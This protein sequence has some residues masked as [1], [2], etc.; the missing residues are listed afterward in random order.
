MFKHR[1]TGAQHNFDC[2]MK[3]KLS[4]QCDS[5]SQL[6]L[7][8]FHFPFSALEANVKSKLYF[9]PGG[10]CISLKGLPWWNKSILT[11]SAPC[12]NAWSSRWFSSGAGLFWKP[13]IIK[14]FS[15]HPSNY[16]RHWYTRLKRKWCLTVSQSFVIP[17][18]ERTHL[19]E[20]KNNCNVHRFNT[21]RFG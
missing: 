13:W 11:N 4:C 18:G 6:S 5:T 2:G 14:T 17:K 1:N 3:K 10:A 15:Y 9:L 20:K 16:E 8:C 7:L 21:K 12:A 19:R